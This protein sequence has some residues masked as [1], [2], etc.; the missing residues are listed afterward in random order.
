MIRTSLAAAIVLAGAT[1]ASAHGYGGYG[2][3]GY[4]NGYANGYGMHR[5]GP[6]VV[7]PHRPMFAPPHWRPW[8][9]FNRFHRHWGW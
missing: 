3:Y 2:T 9:R 5:P 4:G 6:M 1:A 7:A 8:P